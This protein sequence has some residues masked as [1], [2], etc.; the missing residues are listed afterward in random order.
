VIRVQPATQAVAEM[1]KYY[2]NRIQGVQRYM[3]MQPVGGG[4]IWVS[5]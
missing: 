2:G 1:T 5:K 4:S 3:E